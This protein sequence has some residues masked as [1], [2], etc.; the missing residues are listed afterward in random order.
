MSMWM[1]ANERLLPETRIAE[2][3]RDDREPRRRLLARLEL[4]DGGSDPEPERERVA[5]GP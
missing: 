2:L 4:V 3:I 1:R 5:E